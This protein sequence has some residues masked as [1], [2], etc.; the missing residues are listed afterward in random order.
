LNSVR[1]CHVTGSPLP[2]SLLQTYLQ[3][4]IM[5]LNSFGSTETGSGSIMRPEKVREKPASAGLAPFHH[6][7]R[8]V[9]D[10]GVDVALGQVGELVVKGPLRMKEYWRNPQATAEIIKDGWIHTGDLARLDE[11]GFLYIVDRKKDMIISGGENIYPAEIENVLA[12]HPKIQEVAVIGQPDESWGESPC[13]VVRPKPGET[14]TTEDII[15]F[16]QGKI[17]RYKIPK[18]VILTDQPLPRT[19][20]G[21]VLKHVLREQVGISIDKAIRQSKEEERSS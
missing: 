20:A 6:E 15:G 16:C 9:D 2:V 4:G 18:R 13:A 5:V 19:P 14:L 21:K 10:A 12:V 17:G 3:R 7:I 11:E 1:W 8:V